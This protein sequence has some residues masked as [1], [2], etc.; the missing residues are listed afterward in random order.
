MNKDTEMKEHGMCREEPNSLLKNKLQ[1]E[2]EWE[3]RMERWEREHET[4]FLQNIS[5]FN[6]TLKSTRN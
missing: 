4:I 3:I 5:S 2:K 1:G 6:N